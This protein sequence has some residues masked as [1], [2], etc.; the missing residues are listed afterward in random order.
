LYILQS[1]VPAKSLDHEFL[2]E[3]SYSPEEFADIQKNLESKRLR[4]FIR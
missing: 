4:V 1:F 3:I 2:T